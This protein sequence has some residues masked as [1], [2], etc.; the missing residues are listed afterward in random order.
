[1][2]QI[3]L[4]L[5]EAMIKRD[6]INRKYK[7]IYIYG[8]L[9]LFMKSVAL[10]S[11]MLLG[12]IF[13]VPIFVIVFYFSYSIIRAYYGGYHA[14]SRGLCL[15]YS[16]II[17]ITNVLF[18]KFLY[19]SINKAVLVLVMLIAAF[20]FYY[21]NKEDKLKSKLL[22]AANII[23]VLYVAAEF[24]AIYDISKALFAAV[25]SGLFLHVINCRKSQDI[26]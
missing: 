16:N 8:M 1:M 6:I 15:I 20:I 2:E 4:R 25:T 18:V 5:C 11:I 26:E 24:L 7:Q 22:S 17:F 23:L 14:K 3:S 12:I 10:I 13:Q 21:I 9:N 19:G